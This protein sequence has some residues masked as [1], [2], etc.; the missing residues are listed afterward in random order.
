MPYIYFLCQMNS[1]P[2]KRDLPRKMHGHIG[3]LMGPTIF[4]YFL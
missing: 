2:G 4:F 3:Q 1:V